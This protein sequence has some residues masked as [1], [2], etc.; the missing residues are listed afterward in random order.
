VTENE[1]EK[2]YALANV[3]HRKHDI[4][5]Y[6]MKNYVYPKTRKPVFVTY[7]TITAGIRDQTCKI[8]ARRKTVM[9]GKPIAPSKISQG[10]A[11]RNTV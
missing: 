7:D 4:Y 11:S 9:H 3:A 6:V 2:V 5:I 10:N 1:K 8:G